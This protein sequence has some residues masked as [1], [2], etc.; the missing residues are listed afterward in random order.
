[1]K[2]SGLSLFILYAISGTDARHLRGLLVA[3]SVYE[4]YVDTFPRNKTHIGSYPQS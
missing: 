4:E 2:I 1:M 3:S